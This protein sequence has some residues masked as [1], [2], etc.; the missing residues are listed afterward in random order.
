MPVRGDRYIVPS[1]VFSITAAMVEWV[2][3]I[4]RRTRRGTGKC[5]YANVGSKDR[6]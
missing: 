4:T 3:D 1:G 6:M 5:G 2:T